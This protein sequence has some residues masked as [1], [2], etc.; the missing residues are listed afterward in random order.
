MIVDTSAI[1]AIVFQEQGWESVLNRI[2][3]SPDVAAG[4]PTLAETG[5][6]LQARLGND[7]PGMLERMLREFGI[8]EVPFGEAHWR[9]AVD[10][11]RRI[12]KGR[13]AAGL[14]FG[15]CMTYALARLAAEPLLHVGED[16]RRTDITLA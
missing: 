1:L 7:A 9:E 2:V 11:F 16:F 12:G 3:S 15:D 10:A 13:H 4:A 8:Q 5:I 14:N 6:V